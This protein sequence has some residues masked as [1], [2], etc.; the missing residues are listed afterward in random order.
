VNTAPRPRSRRSAARVTGCG[1]HRFAGRPPSYGT[2]GESLPPRGRT[3]EPAAVGA[4][5]DAPAHGRGGVVRVD[6]APGSGKTRPPAEAHAAARPGLRA[7]RAGA[8]PH[9]RAAAAIVRPRLGAARTPRITALASAAAHV[10]GLLDKDLG[11]LPRA[12]PSLRALPADP[13]RCPGPGGTSG[14][15]RRPPAAST[16]FPSWTPRSPSAPRPAPNGTSRLPAA[17]TTRWASAG[18]TTPEGN[19]SGGGAAVSSPRTRSARTGGARSRNSAS[20]HAP[21]RPGRPPTANTERD[22]SL[23]TASGRQGGALVT[24]DEEAPHP[25]HTSDMP[26]SMHGN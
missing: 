23:H 26:D 25:P 2:Q 10:R 18:R 5:L 11:H 6:G 12:C 4:R 9:E 22:R 13:G 3:A 21:A 1:V 8:D 14:G 16:P 24:E 17:G 19:A 20:P 7:L 15:S